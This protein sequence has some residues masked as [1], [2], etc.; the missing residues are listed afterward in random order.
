MQ[1]L[2]V[3]K[4]TTSMKSVTLWARTCSTPLRR[5]TVW[6]DS[7]V[8]PWGRSASTSSTTLDRRSSQS[9]GR[10]NACLASSRV[11]YKRLVRLF[12]DKVTLCSWKISVPGG[13]RSS[14][15]SLFTT[16][17]LSSFTCSFKTQLLGRIWLQITL[18]SP[19][20]HHSAG[21]AGSP[22]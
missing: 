15:L 16:V 22:W 12:L 11:V 14:H 6:V 18:Y 5:T 1:L 17:M 20:I 3:L 9:P 13:F 21:G 8:V 10:L 2:L 19:T 7:V 4:A